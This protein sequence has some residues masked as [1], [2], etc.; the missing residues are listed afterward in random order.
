MTPITKKLKAEWTKALRS[1]K[2]VQGK[3]ALC[4]QVDADHKEWCCLGVL[5]S[6][7]GLLSKDTD[8][9]GC[10]YVADHV[11]K[12]GFLAD[13]DGVPY[14]FDNAL[15]QELA[16][17]NDDSMSFADIADRIEDMVKAV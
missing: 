14:F 8:V 4:K 13:N 6:V 11:Q 16:G 7:A 15:Q 17:Y 1:G 10:H 3:Y 9:E 2:H 5:A 12:T